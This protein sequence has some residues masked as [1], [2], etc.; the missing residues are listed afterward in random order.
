MPSF[1]ICNTKEFSYSKP[2][3]PEIEL[4]VATLDRAVLDYYGTN[5]NVGREAAEWI[6][7]DELSD[8]ALFSFCGIC[9][10]LAIEPGK[11]RQCINNLDFP[12]NIS[13]SHRWLRS[14]VQSKAARSDYI[15]IT[16][17]RAA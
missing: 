11:V 5:T 15:G 12:S 4:L 9:D 3:T 17:K 6:F 8:D 2:V 10:Y 7:S 13:Q 16:T 1:D 14:K